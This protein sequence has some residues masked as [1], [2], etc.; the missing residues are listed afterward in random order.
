MNDA[1]QDAPTKTAPL[2]LRLTPLIILIAFIVLLFATGWDKYLS[3]DVIR[4][5]GRELQAQV[6]EHPVVSLL[7]FIIVYGVLTAMAIPGAIFITLM[8]GFLFGTWLGGTAT[9]I[10]ATLGAVAVYYIVRSAIG[11]WLRHKVEGSQGT[12]RRMRDG[13][14]RNAFSY[15]LTLRLIP[16]VP[17]VLINVVSGIAAVPMR[18][19]VLATFLGI[20]PATFIYSAIGAGLGEVLARG[21]TPNLSV[22]TEPHILLPLLGLAFLSLALPPIVKRMTPKA[23]G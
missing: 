16:V 5:H 3:I 23:A 11:G 13:L 19:Y 18:A 14:D 1:P 4:D 9:A 12:V 7:I 21:E 17:Y 20:L 15:L 6:A 22:L 10:G 8:G 2:A